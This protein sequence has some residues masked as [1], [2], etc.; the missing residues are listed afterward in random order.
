MLLFFDDLDLDHGGDVCWG[1]G[2]RRK[3]DLEMTEDSC[4]GLQ[5]GNRAKGGL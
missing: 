3:D 5:L 1:G 2:R 4:T